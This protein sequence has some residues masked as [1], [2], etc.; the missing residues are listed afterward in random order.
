MNKEYMRNSQYLYYSPIVPSTG[1]RVIT[2]KE[3]NQMARKQYSNNILAKNGGLH[4]RR[5]LK[6]VRQAMTTHKFKKPILYH[7]ILSGKSTK[8]DYQATIK[9]LIEHIR[10]KCK[11]EYIG[12]YEV[13]EEKNGLHCHAFMIVETLDHFPGND[14]LNVSAGYFIARRIAR[15]GMSIKIAPPQNTMH[16]G[17]MFARMDTPAK[18]ANCIDWATYTLKLRSKDAVPGREIYFGSCHA[19][20]ARKREAVRQKYRDAVLKSS[21]PAPQAAQ[22]AL[23]ASVATQ[24]TPFHPIGFPMGRVNHKLTEKASHEEIT[25]PQC[26]TEGQSTDTSPGDRETTSRANHRPVHDCSTGQSEG[27]TSTSDSRYSR[28]SSP[29]AEAIHPGC[30]DDGPA[31]WKPEAV[32]R[33]QSNGR[34]SSQ[35]CDTRSP[36]SHNP[37]EAMLTTAQKYIASRYEEAVDLQLDLDSVRAYLLANGIKRTPAAVVYDLDEVYGFYGYASSHPAP[38]KLS[39]AAMDRM[40]DRMTDADVKLLP[41]PT[42]S[43][44]GLVISRVC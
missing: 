29:G 33:V 41:I 1:T 39:T 20:N 32:Q 36:I 15:T 9:R 34:A 35:G 26:G 18:L 16:D 17:Q 19:A 7:I 14:V 13:G 11:A 25:T 30:Q 21:R 12:A 27:R 31:D 43:A 42:L 6:T 28:D 24:T 44:T 10:T 38:A 5:A 2:M 37:G 22:E 3:S 23:D 4:S 8:A 40:I